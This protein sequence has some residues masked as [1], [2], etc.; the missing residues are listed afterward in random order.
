VIDALRTAAR[1]SLFGSAAAYVLSY[2]A[3]SSVRW[4]ILY[5]FSVACLLAV[6]G[7]CFL[8]LYKGD[9]LATPQP[10]A[11][12]L[13]PSLAALNEQFALR[14]ATGQ[15]HLEDDDAD[16]ACRL[17]REAKGADHP[18][19]AELLYSRALLLATT[20]EPAT[21]VLLAEEAERIWLAALAPGSLELADISFSLA[22]LYQA[23]GEAP[24]AERHY[25]ACAEIAGGLG[26]PGNRLAVSC[27]RLEVTCLQAVGEIC[28]E[29]GDDVEAEALYRRV[30]ELLGDRAAARGK[31][32][33]IAM[34]KLIAVQLARNDYTAARSIVLRAVNL[35]HRAFPDGHPFVA[36]RLDDL[37]RLYHFMGA[38][39]RA[40]PLYERAEQI[41]R[42]IFGRDTPLYSLSLC[43]RAELA[44]ATGNSAEAIE[45][46]G[47]VSDVENQ[48]ILR[49][50][51]GRSERQQ[52]AYT[53]MFYA[54]MCKYLALVVRHY[55]SVPDKVG[56]AFDLVQQ[57]KAAGFEALAA[58]RPV[59][60]ELLAP[61]L[62]DSLERLT[63]LRWKIARMSRAGRS[64][65]ESAALYRH[66]LSSLQAERDD[67]EVELARLAPVP[68]NDTAASDA[69][70]LI[71]W[72]DVPDGAVLI[73]FVRFHVFH[74][75]AVPARREPRWGSPRYLA[76]V[77]LS[78]ISDDV[79]LYDLGEAG[80]IDRWITEFRAEIATDP[81]G[82]RRRD[83]VVQSEPASAPTG[84]SEAGMALYD[85]LLR[86]LSRSIGDRRR[87]LLAPD[88][89]LNR[90][91]FE[92]LPAGEGRRLIEDTE[93]SYV[94]VGRDLLTFAAGT[95]DTADPPLVLADPDFDS[96]EGPSGTN[97]IRSNGGQAIHI[98]SRRS[99]DS[100]LD[101]HSFDRL[102][103]SRA[104]GEEVAALLGVVPV[105]GT[106]AS[107]SRLKACRSPRVLH[108]ATH[109]FFLGDQDL[110]ED[111]LKY[112]LD[113]QPW[114]EDAILEARLVAREATI[115]DIVNLY[116]G[117]VFI[118]QPDLI[119]GLNDLDR[120]MASVRRLTSQAGRL[121][122]L[123]LENPLLRSG[124]ALAGANA[125]LRGEAP[126]HAEDG[127][128]T[129]EDVTGLDLAGTELVVL[130]AC[131]TGL[132]GVRT[133]EGVFG[134]RRAFSL[135]G[136]KTLI[137]S[138]WKVPDEPT[139]ELMVNFYRRL[140]AG[141]GRA[142]ALREAQLSMNARY[143]DP[144]YWGAFICQGDPSPLSMPRTRAQD[145]NTFTERPTVS[146]VSADG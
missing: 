30:L 137:I 50:G 104:E 103:G 63:Q 114:M 128:L 119:A 67:L 48:F 70:R 106:L 134:L 23:L 139:R 101:H 9:E 84:R 123:E 79:D 142:Q 74:F 122:E 107:E 116:G 60:T 95:R 85:I 105:T 8:L 15:S 71:S 124:L 130:S 133:G 53:C 19:L 99:V 77:Y 25:R 34:D 41:R 115:E 21:A 43:N 80:P 94:T 2:D 98:L 64:Q 86:P 136:A 127:L 13:Q 49:A 17:A 42:R 129:A 22:L 40:E 135:A 28:E 111:R 36:D 11:S 46:L 131:E 37:G 144:F 102:P 24:H 82:P 76:F 93:V 62:A 18:V 140:L 88:G 10:E 141:C 109:G 83:L 31:R 39:E 138:L 90:L 118:L 4:A 3:L 32:S 81:A 47:R 38:Y 143:P 7:A 51:A 112:M 61:R 14:A 100:D 20:D 75:D 5:G 110:E 26:R 58:R 72:W 1:I 27:L 87:L 120:E 146:I 78:A 92:V 65:G 69:G 33:L 57:R 113:S 68:E 29:R 97:P 59:I 55:S 89:D 117:W 44:A 145:A 96:V 66:R 16:E 35:T 56:D 12:D 54:N 121:A 45:L 125:G 91:P 132:G 126:L 108:L 6:I 52:M 73:E